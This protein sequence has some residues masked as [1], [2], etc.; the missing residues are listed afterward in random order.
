MIRAGCMETKKVLSFIIL[1]LFLS[2]AIYSQESYYSRYDVDLEEE[3]SFY[4][5]KDDEGQKIFQKFS[6]EGSDYVFKYS[7]ILEMQNEEGV[8][9]PFLTEETEDNFIDCSLSPGEY[10]Y[11]LELYN[12][13]DVVEVVTDWIYVTVERA[14]EPAI[15]DVSP[16]FLYLDDLPDGLFSITGKDIEENSSFRFVN[17]ETGH[18]L[19]VVIVDESLKNRNR[20]K[21]TLQVDPNL[22]EVGDFIITVRNEGGLVADSDPL[23]FKI[24]KA[25]DFC[26]SAGGGLVYNFNPELIKNLF[27]DR[28]MDWNANL[29]LSF[30]FGKTTIGNF[31]AGLGGLFSDFSYDVSDSD[32]YKI[33]APF[34][35]AHIDAVYQKF[36]YARKFLL[37]IHVGAGVGGFINMQIK[38]NDVNNSKSRMFTALG[39]CG[40]GGVAVQFYIFRHFYAELSADYTFALVSGM[41]ISAFTPS[42]SLGMRF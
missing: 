16:D 24:G 37:D 19:P 40:T 3:G 28:E 23:T 11:K 34:F 22:L 5:L 36:V 9:E 29:R 15:T 39:L 2:S 4:V 33:V 7:F 25:L 26:V 32:G 31:G 14:Y 20:S 8:F 41:R 17:V 38:Y 10:R 27:Y 1:L 30:L 18:E 21:V 6:W 35:T 42:L 12:F 13:L